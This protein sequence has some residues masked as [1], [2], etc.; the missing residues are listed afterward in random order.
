MNLKL[1]DGRNIDLPS[2]E[3]AA[4]R[5]V[6]DIILNRGHLPDSDERIKWSTFAETIS[7]KNTDLVRSSE[8]TP[9]L[10]QA[11]EIIIR[12]PVEPNMI[13]TGL[14]DRVQA[15][16]M[17]TQILAGAMGAVYA[18]DIQEHG[19][20][21]EVNFQVGGAVSTAYI[22]KCGIAA[23][24]TDEALR[25]STWDIMAMNLRLMGQ[26]LVRHKEQKA[27]SFLKALGTTLYDNA[28][29]SQSLFGVTAGRDGSLSGNGSMT[30]DDLMR[31]FAHMSQEGFTP[32]I[33]LVHPLQ[34]YSF[35]QDPVLRDMMLAHGGGSWFN[36]YQ[37]NPGPLN[38][39]NNGRMGAMGPSAGRSIVPPGSPGG[40][41]TRET[42]YSQ[43]ATS[44]PNL[45]SYMPLDFQVMASPLVPFDVDQ[46]MGDVFLLSRNNVGYYL[47]DEDAQTVE[48]R[49]ENVDVTK[50]KIR[51]R[52]GF[53]VKHEG[54]GVGVFRNVKAD[55]NYFNGQVNATLDAGGATIPLP[56]STPVV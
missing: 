1:A 14:Y 4:A 12:E 46:N 5:Y 35:M 41:A 34:F 8:I 6:A 45:P 29:P 33:L 16:G 10:Q 15:Q 11:T 27:A 38:P 31:A 9:L 47:V 13:I 28:T 51:E 53:A 25:Y 24:F 18:Q 17:N 54:Q 37:G 7:P 55:R 50:V 39:Y 3:D 30:M 21:P 56:P 48:W 43:R 26:A 36:P 2:N 23:A 32:N 44:V 40:T 20:Y 19:Q 22:G 52:Y 49:D 42:G